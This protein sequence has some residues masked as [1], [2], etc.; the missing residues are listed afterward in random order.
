MS[1]LIRSLRWLYVM[2]DQTN[3][4]GAGPLYAQ[5][6]KGFAA[7]WANLARVSWK[8]DAVPIAGSA[9]RASISWSVEQ[10]AVVWGSVS[11][12]LIRPVQT[13]NHPRATLLHHHPSRSVIL[14]PA[15]RAM[16][17]APCCA[18]YAVRLAT[19]SLPWLCVYRYNSA[20]CADSRA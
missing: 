15:H 6:F 18:S 3:V 2:C 12:T 19:A 9:E 10:Y 4:G 16:S 11:W 20:P 8:Y 13:N 5:L 1:S 17:A 7:N 14:R